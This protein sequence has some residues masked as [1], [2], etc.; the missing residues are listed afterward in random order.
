MPARTPNGQVI[1]ETLPD[2]LF[3]DLFP[4]GRGRPSVPADVIT[5]AFVLKEL[6]GLSDRQAAAALTRDIAWK[7]AC[8][9]ALDAESFDA[10]VFV[11]WRRRLNASGRPHRIDEAVKD[12][13]RQ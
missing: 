11:Y 12:V 3:A 8:G 2:E 1:P 7:V 10:S 9:L 5:S 4:S 6:E 13:A